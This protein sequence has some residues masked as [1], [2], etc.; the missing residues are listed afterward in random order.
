MLI[1]APLQKAHPL[2]AKLPP[3]ILISPTYGCAIFLLQ[4]LS[5]TV[6]LILYLI[7]NLDH[8][9]EYRFV[10]SP[11]V[12]PANGNQKQIEVADGIVLHGIDA[13]RKHLI[14]IAAEAQRKLFLPRRGMPIADFDQIHGMRFRVLIEEPELRIKLLF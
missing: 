11:G 2:I 7:L 5:L 3:N 13:L 10:K 9:I 8:A 12:I 1:N 6:N 4:L 14:P